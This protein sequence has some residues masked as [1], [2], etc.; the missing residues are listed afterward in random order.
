[1]YKAIVNTYLSYSNEKIYIKTNVSN[2]NE[3]I[4]HILL[5]KDSYC[6]K[7]WITNIDIGT[8]I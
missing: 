3:I 1:M 8:K 2:H 6:Y 4:M 5:S 7:Y